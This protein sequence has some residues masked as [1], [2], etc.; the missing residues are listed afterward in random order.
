MISD[1]RRVYKCLDNIFGQKFNNYTNRPYGMFHAK[2][3]DVVK[4]YIIS[5]FIVK[6][7]VE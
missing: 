1:V 2:T 3:D 6:K 5:Q 4:N 7:P